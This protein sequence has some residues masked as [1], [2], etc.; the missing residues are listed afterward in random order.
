LEPRFI[1]SSIFL[2]GGEA[3]LSKKMNPKARSSEE[4]GVD[5]SFVQFLDKDIQGN[6]MAFGLKSIFGTSGLRVKTS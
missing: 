2:R 5:H 3:C 6:C 4:E 1:V